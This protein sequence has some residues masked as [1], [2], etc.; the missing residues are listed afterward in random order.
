MP[1]SPAFDFAVLQLSEENADL[2]MKYGSWYQALHFGH[3]SPLTSGQ[4]RFR[5]CA[6]W[7]KAPISE[8]E[9]AY[10]NYLNAVGVATNKQHLSE[11]PPIDRIPEPDIPKLEVNAWMCDYSELSRRPESYYDMIIYPNLD[12]PGENPNLDI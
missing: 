4:I 3:I 10:V 5:D 8:H 11:N 12:G 6:T 2:L 7:K 1:F 9:I